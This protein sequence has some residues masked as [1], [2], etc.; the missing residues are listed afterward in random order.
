MWWAPYLKLAI[1]KSFDQLRRRGLP[2]VSFVYFGWFTPVCSVRA[3]P[4]QSSLLDFYP[5]SKKTQRIIDIHPLESEQ[6]SHSEI[7]LFWNGLHSF[8]THTKYE[9]GGTDASVW[10]TLVI[11]VQGQYDLLSFRLISSLFFYFSISFQFVNLDYFAP[12]LKKIN[13]MSQWHFPILC[14]NVIQIPSKVFLIFYFGLSVGDLAISTPADTAFLPELV[15]ITRGLWSCWGLMANWKVSQV[16]V[17]V[18]ALGSSKK[19]Y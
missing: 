13:S 2:L 1:S 18:V 12:G 4:T 9:T 7:S 19:G 15:H 10:L 3:P 14:E 11:H 17:I 5:V 6:T 16:K 8:R